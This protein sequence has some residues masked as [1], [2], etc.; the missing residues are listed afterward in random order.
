MIGFER[1]L[2]LKQRGKVTL[3]VP[4]DK[5][6]AIFSYT[7]EQ[8]VAYYHVLVYKSSRSSTPSRSITECGHGS[9]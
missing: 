3:E 1:G 8:S 9:I 7:H 2:V 5:N 6:Y 4:I